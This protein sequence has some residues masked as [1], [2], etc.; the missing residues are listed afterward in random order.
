MTEQRPQRTTMNAGP[1]HPGT[2]PP[3][4]WCAG[5]ISEGVPAAV[6]VTLYRGSALCAPHVAVAASKSAWW[7]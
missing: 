3:L 1:T 2:A 6:A 7:R 5:C 4:G